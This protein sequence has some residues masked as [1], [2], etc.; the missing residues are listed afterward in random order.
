MDQGLFGELSM[1]P[2]SFLS[3]NVTVTAPP[4][5]FQNLPAHLDCEELG[6]SAIYRSTSKDP[7]HSGGTVYTVEELE[8]H[9]DKERQ[10]N[11]P[12][13]QQRLLLFLLLHYNDPFT[14]QLS[15]VVG[16]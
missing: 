3:P 16:W 5:F 14:V 2:F 1:Q 11:L 10:Q 7:L 15:D 13:L 8:N 12:P 6:L 9:E 4:S